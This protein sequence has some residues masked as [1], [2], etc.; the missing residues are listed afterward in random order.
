MGD[1]LATDANKVVDVASGVVVAA[2]AVEI[3]RTRD[4]SVERTRKRWNSCS[5]QVH[6]GP[7]NTLCRESSRSVAETESAVQEHLASPPD[8]EE[9]R[10]DRVEE[11]PAVPPGKV[12]LPDEDALPGV[13]LSGPL[14]ETDDG[15]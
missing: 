6:D 12:D 7:D 8:S 5:V 3:T 11:E 10:G 9:D 14:D 1:N 15:L 2:L 4:P 13:P